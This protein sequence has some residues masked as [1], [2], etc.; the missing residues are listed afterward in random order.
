LSAC[1]LE[2]NKKTY[3]IIEISYN[4]F[5]STNGISYIY[6]VFLNACIR[7]RSFTTDRVPRLNRLFLFSLAKTV[8]NGRGDR[9]GLFFTYFIIYNDAVRRQIVMCDNIYTF[10]RKNE[11]VVYCFVKCIRNFSKSIVLSNSFIR[12]RTRLIL[13]N[14]SQ[15]NNVCVLFVQ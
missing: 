8:W 9:R 1:C 11:T 7:T 10:S 5:I 2:K 13:E 14:V 6:N 12:N 15:H 4:N 3:E